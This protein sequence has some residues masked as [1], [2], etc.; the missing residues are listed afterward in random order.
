[1]TA[2]ASYPN[3]HLLW[4]PQQLQAR[5][6]EAELI[7]LDLRPAEEM[8]SGVIPGAVHLDLYGIGLSSTQ[9][10]LF[11]EFVGLM[12]AQ[13]ATRGIT[14]E[15]TV[16]L[17]EQAQTGTRVGRAFWLLEYLGHTDT[18][19][20]DGGMAAWLAA[21]GATTQE[22]TAPLRGRL[23]EACQERI[24]ISADELHGLLDDPGT[25]VLDTRSAEENDGRNT[26]GGPRGGTIPGAVHLEWQ[27]TLDASGRTKPAAELAALFEGLGVLRDK[28]IVPF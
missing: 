5:L 28:A 25:V 7:V 10:T 2:K 26:R 20:L 16:L 15:R 22:M 27:H 19:V 23:R 12:R 9:G 17:Y 11:E 18:H 24:Y 14:P 4:S 3:A 21:G 6:G 1:M 13:L 8:I